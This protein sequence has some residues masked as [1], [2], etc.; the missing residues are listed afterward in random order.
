[1]FLFLDFQYFYNELFGWIDCAYNCGLPRRAVSTLKRLRLFVLDLQC[2]LLLLLLL[3]L[4]LEAPLLTLLLLL[5][6]LLLLRPQYFSRLFLFSS[7][8]PSPCPANDF[9]SDFF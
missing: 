9:Y 2:A 6:L 4:I 1:M 3:I 5:L 8:V 7:I